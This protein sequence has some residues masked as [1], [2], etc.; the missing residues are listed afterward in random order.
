MHL[1]PA[2]QLDL[3]SA[4]RSE[5]SAELAALLAQ[6]HAIAQGVD[7]IDQQQ[8]Q[9][10]EEVARLSAVLADL[11]RRAAA[12]EEVSDAQRT[13]AEQAL[14]KARSKAAEPWAERRGGQQAAARD[15]DRKV[16]LF[17]GENFPALYGDLAED[18]EAAAAS[19][20]SAA[21]ALVSA[22]HERM[23]VEQRV[24]ALSAWVRAPH[25]GNVA[26]TRSEAVVREAERL[27]AEGGERAPLLRDDPRQA[28]SVEPTVTPEREP[29][30]V[31]AT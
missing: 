22:Y 26:G 25:P 28:A 16:A 6:G 12:G 20:D 21:R 1:N 29:E 5:A 15:H 17:V 23:A 27:L 31:T 30:P 2:A 9:A 4:P 18:A 19:V 13:K 24:T 3:G 8:R 11:E 14:T 7:D 10:T